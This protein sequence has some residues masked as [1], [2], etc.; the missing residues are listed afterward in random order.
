LREGRKGKERKNESL[1]LYY[2]HTRWLKRGKGPFERI[3]L[4]KQDLRS[5]EKKKK[6][7]KR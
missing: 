2:A 5:G 3:K 4:R 1:E 6:R 7:R